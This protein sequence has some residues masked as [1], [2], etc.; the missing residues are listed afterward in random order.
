M[1]DLIRVHLSAAEDRG[2]AHGPRWKR[3]VMGKWRR[4]QI[5]RVVRIEVVEVD[6]LL[7][8]VDDRVRI[9]QI[10]AKGVDLPAADM[11]SGAQRSE[12]RGGVF[13]REWSELAR[14]R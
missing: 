3:E 10:V 12:V 2:Y 4:R 9:E 1:S 7:L 13:E 11:R 5:G 6:A 14:P 8:I